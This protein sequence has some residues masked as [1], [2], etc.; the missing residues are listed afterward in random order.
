MEE[1]NHDEAQ[2]SYERC[3]QCIR[4]AERESRAILDAHCDAQESYGAV[5]RAMRDAWSA[6][7]ANSGPVTSKGGLKDT[8]PDLDDATKA[9][10]GRKRDLDLLRLQ[11]V[12]LGIG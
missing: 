8:E 11:G 4:A 12:A 10:R 6:L 3:Q 7:G 5:S 9:R 1:G 2:E